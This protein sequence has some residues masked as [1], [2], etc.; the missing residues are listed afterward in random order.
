MYILDPAAAHNMPALGHAI[1]GQALRAGDVCVA[2]Q[3]E[4]G[5]VFSTLVPAGFSCLPSHN[6]KQS[7]KTIERIS[8]EFPRF[9]CA[10]KAEMQF[11]EWPQNSKLRNG[12]KIILM[13]IVCNAS[14]QNMIPKN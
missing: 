8:K 3:H 11:N 1:G 12:E 13:I 4:P 10:I 7:L 14:L 5:R 2:A 6:T 9:P